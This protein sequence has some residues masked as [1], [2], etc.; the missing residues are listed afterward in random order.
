MRL[1]LV[2]LMC[3]GV[4]AW[5]KPQPHARSGIRSL[6]MFN[7]YRPQEARTAV[8]SSSS[9]A[10][11][12]ALHSMRLDGRSSSMALRFKVYED[13]DVE[14]DEEEI[15]FDDFSGGI[16]GNSAMLRK[17]GKGVMPI[18]LGLGFAATPR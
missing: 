15:E 5:L 10:S 11:A 9:V 3:V 18:G 6:G 12:P 17:L 4:A 7:A 13:E 8:G 16:A 1:F 2:L 14:V